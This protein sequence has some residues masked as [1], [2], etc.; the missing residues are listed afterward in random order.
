MA[1]ISPFRALSPTPPFGTRCRRRALRRRQHR[2]GA[3]ARRRQSAELS[4]TCR[5][6]RSICRGGTNPYGDAVYAKAVE[7]FERPES[8]G[9]A[10]ARGRRRRSTSTGCGWAGARADRRRR[11]LLGRRVRRRCHQEARADAAGQG[12]RPHATHPRAARADRAG[13]PDP[14][15]VARRRRRCAADD[16]RERR[17]SISP[18]STACSTRSGGS[19]PGDTPALVVGVRARCPSLYIADGHHRAASAARARQQLRGGGRVG[20]VGHVPRRR[21]SRRSDAGACPTTAS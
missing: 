21:V 10:R 8:A 12:R 17:S 9:A 13:V 3:R 1:T 14:S 2:R 20:R 5:V 4:C 16:R 18:P 7:N 11:L 15:G 19:T 6:P